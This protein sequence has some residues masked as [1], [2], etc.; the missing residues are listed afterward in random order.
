MD[1]NLYEECKALGIPINNHSSDLYIPV[2]PETTALIRK[3]GHRATTF[4]NQV[5]G[6][7]WYDVPFAYLPFWKASGEEASVIMI[8]ETG[9]IV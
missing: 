8:D 4:K 1:D 9:A 2:T 7:I 5:E 3:H 6:G